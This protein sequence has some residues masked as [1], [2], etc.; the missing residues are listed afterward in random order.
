MTTTTVRYNLV[1]GPEKYDL[2]TALFTREATMTITIE[3][4]NRNAKEIFKVTLEGVEKADKAV[5]A[6]SSTVP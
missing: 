6:S 5:P 3:P 2:A 4:R 1:D